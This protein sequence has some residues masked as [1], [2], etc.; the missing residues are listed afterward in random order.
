MDGF[1]LASGQ[2][3]DIVGTGDGLTN[4]LTSLSLNGRACCG[5]RAA[6]FKC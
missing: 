5:S 3:F 2:T 6:S 4:G 1:T